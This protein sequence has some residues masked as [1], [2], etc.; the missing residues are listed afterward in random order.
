M[1]F[2][3]Y[4]STFIYTSPFHVFLFHSQL[5]FCPFLVFVH[6]CFIL[7]HFNFSL[8]FPSHLFLPILLLILPSP[9]SLFSSRHRLPPFSSFFFSLCYLIPFFKYPSSSSVSFCSLTL[10]YMMLFLPFHHSLHFLFPTSTS[11]F[12]LF[13]STFSF[14]FYFNLLS[15]ILSSYSSSFPLLSP[16]PATPTPFFSP[17]LSSSSRSIFHPSKPQYLR[18][19]ECV[20]LRR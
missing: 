5:F 18:L 19:I 13:L 8:L 1:C 14:P 17:S 10:P 9:S 11:P 15:L 12:P 2:L 7:F 16:P 3:L 4:Y 6:L 20:S